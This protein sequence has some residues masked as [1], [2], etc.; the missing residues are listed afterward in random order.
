MLQSNRSR[1]RAVTILTAALLTTTGLTV[2][3]DENPVPLP[4][5]ASIEID[6]V[7]DVQPIL[8]TRCHRCHGPSAQKSD[9]RLDRRKG[10]LEGGSLG[11]AIVPGNSGASRLIHYVAGTDR[12]LR[13]PPKGRP[14]TREQVGIL[15]AW[16]DQGVPWP[17][18][19]ED[20]EDEAETEARP[21]S[22]APL[23]KPSAPQTRR[24]EWIRTPI[25]AFVL[26]RLEE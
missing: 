9:Y 15:R 13:M 8:K 18:S 6:F 10:A 3:G 7:R 14:L 20:D 1:C 25:D 26:A 11:G 5:T 4:P 22:L 21:W 12:K 2:T 16:I 17:A 19:D 23:R 24:A